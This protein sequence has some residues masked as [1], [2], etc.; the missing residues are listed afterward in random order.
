MLR[1]EPRLR[2]QVALQQFRQRGH[3]DADAR[4][5]EENAAGSHAAHDS[6][7]GSMVYSFITVSFRL[8]MRL[9]TLV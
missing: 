7:R 2:E 6:T 5:P 9:V 8:R 1:S 3:A 4:L